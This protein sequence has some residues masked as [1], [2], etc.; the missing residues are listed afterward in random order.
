M[1]DQ[2][3]FRYIEQAAEIADLLDQYAA[4]GNGQRYDD[5]GRRSG[6]ASTKAP[7][8]IDV[9]SAVHDHDRDQIQE[10]GIRQAILEP[11]D[12]PGLYI[13][14]SDRAARGALLAQLLDDE[15][16]LEAV[17]GHTTVAMRRH[18]TVLVCVLADAEGHVRLRCPRNHAPIEGIPTRTVV[19]A[20]MLDIPTGLVVCVHPECDE[21][22]GVPRLLNLVQEM[23]TND[24]EAL[25]GYEEIAL[26]LGVSIEAAK[27]KIRRAREKGYDVPVVDYRIS[28]KGQKQAVHRLTDLIKANNIARD[29]GINIADWPKQPRRRRHPN[30]GT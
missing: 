19:P 11:L 10:L 25:L 2:R 26:L 8:R 5:D 27:A 23:L 4:A 9:T 21:T 13:P 22:P 20:A 29:L 24:P 15:D 28:S 1:T 16:D 30:P 12:G 14:R 3:R 17:A 7:V 6:D 18:Y